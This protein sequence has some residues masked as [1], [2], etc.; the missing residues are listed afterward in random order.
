MFTTTIYI[1]SY[2]FVSLVNFISKLKNVLTYYVGIFKLVQKIRNSITKTSFVYYNN[3]FKN[4]RKN[5]LE[6]NLTSILKNTKIC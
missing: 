4:K 5:Q 1:M 2:L 3:N 6:Y